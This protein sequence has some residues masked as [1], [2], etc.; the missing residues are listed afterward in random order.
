MLSIKINNF[1]PI[2]TKLRQND[3]VKIVDFMDNDKFL[4]QSQF[5]LYVLSMGRFLRMVDFRDKN[6]GN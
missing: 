1:Y 5:T 2:I 6:I 4:G 3:W